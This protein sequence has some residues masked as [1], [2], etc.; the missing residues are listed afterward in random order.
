MVQKIFCLIFLE[1]S[2]PK[3]VL[4]NIQN[5]LVQKIIVII[6]TCYNSKCPNIP[7]TTDVSKTKCFNS[8]CK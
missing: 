2:V 8:F 4:K 6:K 1:Q 7:Y 3:Y 5:N